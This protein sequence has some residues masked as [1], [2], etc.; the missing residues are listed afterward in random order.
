MKPYKFLLILL[1]LS[2]SS[3]I[4]ASAQ[5]NFWAPNYNSPASITKDKA[6]ARLSFPQT[7]TLFNLDIE[8]L[9]QQL[10]TIVDSTALPRSTVIFLPSAD[11]VYEQ[12]EVFE[13]S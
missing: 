9:R 7:F 12:F 1:G 3:I 10:F 11:G 8:P 4:E 5:S 13:A 6:V 2:T